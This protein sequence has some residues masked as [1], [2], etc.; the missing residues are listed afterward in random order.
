MHYDLH[1]PLT[2]N[3]ISLLRAG[4]TVTLSGVI[5]TARDAAHKLICEQLERG[6]TLPLDLDGACIYYAGPCPAAPGEVIGPCGPTTSYRMDAYTPTLI[7]H[8]QNAM[9]GKGFRSAEV[10]EAMRGKAVYFAA[11]GGAA[12]LISRC[13]KSA[14]VIGYPQLG[15]EAVRRLTVE[16]LPLVVAIDAVGGNLYDRG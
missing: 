5:Y 11:T 16:K 10:V 2:Q 4:D 15:A 1:L 6:E 14:E 13:V 3:D 8:G 7:A 12:V 9:I